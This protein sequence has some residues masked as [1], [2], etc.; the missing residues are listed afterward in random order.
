MRIQFCRA[1]VALLLAVLLE[2][3]HEGGLVLGGLEPSVAE[4]GAGVDELEVDL[5][6]SPLLGVSEERLSQGEGPLLGSNAAALDH[7]EVLLDLSVVREATHWVDGLVSNVILGGSVVLHELAILHVV[8]SAH[9][10]DLLV[11][12][13]PVAVALLTGPGHSALDP[14]WMPGSDTG[15]LP[16]TLVSLPGQLLGVPPAGDALVSVTLGDTDHVDHLVLGK[17]LADGN[18]LLKV[19]TGKVDLVGNGTTVQLDL[20]DVRLLL[21][22]AE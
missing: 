14:A 2:G 1:L 12:L 13:S 17:H 4:L 19:L 10:V 8:A 18:L 9:P 22:A 5:L 7:D 11:H 15:D 6:K 21:P 20:H 16:Q 3:T